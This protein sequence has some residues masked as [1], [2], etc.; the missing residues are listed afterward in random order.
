MSFQK[1]KMLADGDNSPNILYK[2]IKIEY[3]V[4]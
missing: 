2:K 1:E 4:Y 3:V